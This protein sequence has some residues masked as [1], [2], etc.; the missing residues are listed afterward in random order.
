MK[1]NIRAEGLFKK[2]NVEEDEEEVVETE[3]SYHLPA[4]R[5]NISN[6]EELTDALEDSTKQILLKIQ[7][8]EGTKSNLNFQK[9]ILSITLHFD[10]Y[11]PTRAGSFIELPRFVKLKKACVNI[12][13][14][15]NQ[16]IKYCVQS[17][18]YDKI[19]KHHP[20][21]MFHYKNIN[22]DIINWEGVKFPTGNR[23]ID[24]FEENNKGLISINV[25]EVDEVL[26]DEKVIK[27]RTTKIKYAKHHIDLLKVYDENNVSHYAIIKSISRLLNC[28]INK[29]EKLKHICRYCTTAFSRKDLLDKHI[30]KGCMAIEGQNIKLP[31]KGEYLEFEKYNTKLK[32]PFVIYGDFECLT[33]PS[34]DGIKGTYQHHK[35]CG[36]MLNV[37]N[38]I[39]NSCQPY[40]YRGEDCMD[41]FVEQL[42]EIKETILSKMK[43]N[44]PMEKLTEEQQ[45]QF[46]NA[47]R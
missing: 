15:D 36:Y 17:T 29:N 23:D 13:N 10:K 38:S 20:E 32:C 14:Q 43:T 47:T 31:K 35:P 11:D 7:D 5:Y 1:L 21:E 27:H 2:Q 30:E 40:L 39:D 37:K 8:L 34:S 41:K 3:Q 18:V 44:L 12:K 25:F 4:T 33:T 42:S 46:K 6:E 19:S 26:N 22:D 45:L 24:R 16:I 9:K 28:Q